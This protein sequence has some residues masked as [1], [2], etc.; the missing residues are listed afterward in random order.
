MLQE[1]FYKFI[2]M[3][4]RVSARNV[5]ILTVGFNGFSACTRSNTSRLSGEGLSNDVSRV[6]R[7]LGGIWE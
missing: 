5:S 1:N 3:K 4:G 2:Q 7:H 6:N